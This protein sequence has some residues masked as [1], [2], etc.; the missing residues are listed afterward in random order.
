MIYEER[1]TVWLRESMNSA[2]E[3]AE[4]EAQRYTRYIRFT[5][6]GLAQGYRM[7]GDKVGEDAKEIGDGKEVFSL[8]RQSTLS[9][10]E[11]LSRFFDT[12]SEI[13]DRP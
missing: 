7:F 3:A 1:I 8:C 10:E 12:G 5:Y 11:Y 13:Q 2:I 9:T 6:T 4:E